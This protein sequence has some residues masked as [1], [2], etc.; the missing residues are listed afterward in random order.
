[1]PEG[2][3]EDLAKKIEYSFRPCRVGGWRGS[4]GQF[5][6]SFESIKEITKLN[7]QA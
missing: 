2:A 6:K 5:V 7:K 1:M 4:V 3:G